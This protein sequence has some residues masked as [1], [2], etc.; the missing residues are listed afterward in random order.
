MTIKNK[1]TKEAV[2]FCNLNVMPI[3][4]SMAA[5]HN[6]KISRVTN[7][8]RNQDNSANELEQELIYNYQVQIE[9]GKDLKPLLKE[10]DDI[11]TFYMPIVTNQMCM[12]CH[13]AKS[14]I[15]TETLKEINRL[16]PKDMATGYIPQQIRGIWRVVMEK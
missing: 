7:R 15:D 9:S 6:T 1:G 8:A 14:E 12:K 2:S 13:S 3:I 10:T 5:I 16:Y 11:A 4:D